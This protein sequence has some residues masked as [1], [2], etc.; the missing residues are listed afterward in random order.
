MLKLL[1]ALGVVL[2]A[3]ATIT[4]FAPAAAVSAGS[5]PEK[6]P[7][8]GIASVSLGNV[9]FGSTETFHIHP[10]KSSVQ[11]TSD[12]LNLYF[13]S[14]VVSPIND[15]MSLNDSIH[16]SKN[17]LKVNFPV[18]NGTYNLSNPPQQSY[19]NSIS[20]EGNSSY[21]YLTIVESIP[22]QEIY[23]NGTSIAGAQHVQNSS[24]YNLTAHFDNLSFVLYSP[25]A[26]TVGK[27]LSPVSLYIDAA[28]AGRNSLLSFS[29]PLNGGHFS[30]VF[31]Q[32]LSSGQPINNYVLS[33][34][35]INGF[36]SPLM[37]NLASNSVSIAIGGSIFAVLILGIFVYYKRK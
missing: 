20:I 6:V 15:T 24:F 9:P 33:Y 27:I 35:Q 10:G 22:T 2:V 36:K 14:S 25:G 30:F 13:D 34:Y 16:L 31:N 23:L 3:I 17:P 1:V 29:F 37:Q 7:I 19:I 18:Q 12:V 21:S 28:G 32:V 26:V 11:R 4:A 8:I 5:S